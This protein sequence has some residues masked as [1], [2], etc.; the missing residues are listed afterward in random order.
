M[1]S[2]P[3]YVASRTLAT[4]DWANATLLPG[5]AATAVRDLKGRGDGDLFVFGSADLS[6]TLI[7]E[8]LF[9]EYRLL[10]VPVVL[11]EGRPLFARGSDRRKLRLLETRPMGAGGVFARYAPA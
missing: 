8:G 11:G 2:L 9:D 1:N 5:D 6:A 10:L 3:K 4:V 7:R